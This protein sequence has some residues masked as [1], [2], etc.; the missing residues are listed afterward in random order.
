MQAVIEVPVK[1]EE[2]DELF[3]TESSSGSSRGSDYVPEGHSRVKASRPLVKRVRAPP[4]Q[5]DL[6]SVTSEEEEEPRW[7]PT[8][9][10]RVISD[11]NDDDEDDELLLG[12]KV[13]CLKICFPQLDS[14]IYLR[15]IFSFSLKSNDESYYDISPLNNAGLAPKQRR[16]SIGSGILSSGQKRKRGE[17]TVS[18]TSTT[19]VTRKQ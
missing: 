14:H 9:T 5:F 15:L 12:R 7:K 10:R 17:T 11:Q 18:R 6:D 3:A 1:E 8:K 4:A 13:S 2:D 19:K 16:A